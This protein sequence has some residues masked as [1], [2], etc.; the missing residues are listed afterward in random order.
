[1]QMS[2]I[3]MVLAAISRYFDFNKFLEIKIHVG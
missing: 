2:A 1:M 3:W